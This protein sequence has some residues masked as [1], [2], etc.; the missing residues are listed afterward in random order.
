MV[1]VSWAETPAPKRAIERKER[2]E[3]FITRAEYKKG[4]GGWV[5]RSWVGRK[6]ATSRGGGNDISH[7]YLQAPPPNNPLSGWV[8]ARQ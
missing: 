3:N 2:A 1:K 5:E 4:E 8:C 6:T 7:G